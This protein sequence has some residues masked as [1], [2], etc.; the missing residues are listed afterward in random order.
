MAPMTTGTRIFASIAI[1]LMLTLIIS[2]CA[3]S[4][5]GTLNDTFD[6]SVNKSVAKILLAD[7]LNKAKSDMVAA[8]RL[9]VIGA[10]TK[11]A[12]QLNIGTAAFRRHLEIC[13]QSLEA[14]RPLHVSDEGRRM[15]SEIETKL[16]EWRTI[17]QELEIAA[18]NGNIAEAERIRAEK[19]VPVYKAIDDMATRL[20]E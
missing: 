15:T 3:L 18:R 4:I 2:F 10:A 13:Q 20:T 8:Q 9:V 7:K 5:I 16:R 6:R 17:F 1:L 14:F 19:T 12:D 11:S